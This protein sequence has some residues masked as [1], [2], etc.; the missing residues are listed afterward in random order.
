M[1]LNRRQLVELA[2]Q[3]AEERYRELLEDFEGYFDDDSPG[4]LQE[5]AD[6]C[7]QIGAAFPSRPVEGTFAQLRNDI[8]TRAAEIERELAK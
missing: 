4:L 6:E 8:L 5:W 1:K 2:L 7:H 3:R